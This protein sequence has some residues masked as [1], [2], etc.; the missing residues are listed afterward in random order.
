MAFTVFE[1][2]SIATDIG[3]TIMNVNGEMKFKS[4]KYKA[5]AEFLST[6][7]D[8]LDAT[9]SDRIAL[10]YGCYQ[11]RRF[12]GRYIFMT[13]SGLTYCVSPLAQDFSEMEEALIAGPFLMT[14]HNEYLDI[15]ILEHHEL[16]DSV[17]EV[18]RSGINTIPFRLPTQ[19]QALSELLFVSSVYHLGKRIVPIPEFKQTDTDTFAYSI[20]QENELLVSVSIGDVN[21]ASAVLNDILGKTLLGAG[22]NFEV[23]RSRV[24]ELTVLLSRASLKGG[25]N[26]DAIFGLNYGYLREIDALSSVDDI[27]AWVNDVMHRFVQHVFDYANSKYVDVI[28]KSMAYIKENYTNKISLQDVADAVHLNVTYFSK[29]FKDET[30]QTPGNY[31]TSL[32]IEESKKLLKN[33]SINM[34]D[35]PELIGF[36][37]QSY[38]IQIFKKAVGCTPGQYRRKLLQDAR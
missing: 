2:L 14:E 31:I 13:P 3:V 10:I 12:G 17:V 38:F 8:A 35:I 16:S 11:A 19:V 25:A 21:T 4:S 5:S 28:F 7:L 23:L 30:G 36:E 37:S 29:V 22:N 9:E 6:L 27:V 33:M 26:L 18:L 34:A 1:H 24:V 15:D 20:E 32:R